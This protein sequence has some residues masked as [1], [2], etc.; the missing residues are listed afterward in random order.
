M[1][2]LRI[3]KS[4]LNLEKKKQIYMVKFNLQW[5]QVETY[6]LTLGSLI[7]NFKDNKSYYIMLNIRFS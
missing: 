6:S 2:Y 3:L 1:F 5:Q 4:Y 7:K